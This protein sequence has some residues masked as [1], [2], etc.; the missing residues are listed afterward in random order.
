MHACRMKDS[1][2]IDD[3]NK[4]M[5]VINIIAEDCFVFAISELMNSRS[6]RI[7]MGCNLCGRDDM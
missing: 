7:E 6:R 5:D 3:I 2:Y 4:D 1:T